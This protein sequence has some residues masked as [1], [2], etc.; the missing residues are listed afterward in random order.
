MSSVSLL[1]RITLTGLGLVTPFGA[2]QACFFGALADGKSALR[3]V[4]EL[5]SDLPP[6]CAGK[7]VWAA[8]VPDFGA[9]GAIEA[10]KRRRMP[11]LCQMTIVAAREAL[12]LAPGQK[13]EEAA[14]KRRYAAERIGVVLGTGLGALE[15]TIEF[16][17]S[18]IKGGVGAGSPAVFPYTVMNASAGLLAMEFGFCGPNVTVN[19]R[20]LS[21]PEALA[22]GA[23]LLLTGRADAVL[24][25]G[26]DELG[27]SLYHALWALGAL[28]DGFASPDGGR[29][30][31]YENKNG[32]VLP[33]E[34]AVICLLERE[35]AAFDAKPLAVLSGWDRSGDD[36]PRLGW[37]RA[38]GPSLTGEGTRHTEEVVS[39]AARSIEKSLCHA[40]IAKADISYIVGSGDGSALDGLETQACRSALGFHSERVRIS[41][42]LGQF[43]QSFVAPGF[44]LASALWAFAHNTLPG[45]T[46]CTTPDPRVSLP[47]LCLSPTEQSVKHVLFPTFSEGG[48]NLSFVL[49]RA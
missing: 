46:H 19:H 32:G 47:G 34:G 1:P 16:T 24:C 33:G 28:A 7:P 43:G 18:L 44:R 21:V 49:S 45:T 5:S 17:K 13:P 9:D 37:P 10:G 3:E 8:R 36:R 6:D 48:A 12:G 30:F 38:A 4:S 14:I 31:P 22:T 23:E 29:L 25:G 39:H 20:A 41:S 35:T 15:S 2:G 26:C 11:R 40:G 42:I 27:P